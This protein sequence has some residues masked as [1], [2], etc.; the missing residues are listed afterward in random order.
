M[1]GRLEDWTHVVRRH[2]HDTKA[3]I[4]SSRKPPCL[5]MAKDEVRHIQRWMEHVLLDALPHKLPGSWF[6]AVIVCPGDDL[7][8]LAQWMTRHGGERVRFYLHRDADFQQLAPVRDAGHE[9]RHVRPET[10]TTYGA[11]HQ[12]LGLDLSDQVYEDYRGK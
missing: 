4:V 3:L 1:K 7:T 5:T 10:Y 6:M 11:M 2:A 12:R 8:G 9:L